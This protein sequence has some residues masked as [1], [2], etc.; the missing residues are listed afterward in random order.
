MQALSPCLLT[1]CTEFDTDSKM[2]FQTTK[3]VKPVKTFEAMGLKEQL[4]RGIYA[5]G[6]RGVEQPTHIHA[7]HSPSPPPPLAPLCRLREALC[8]SAAR[9]HAGAGGA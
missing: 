4:L 7:A 9:H 2:L 3:D 8:H 6:A 5:Y 1:P